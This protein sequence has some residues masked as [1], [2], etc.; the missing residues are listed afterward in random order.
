MV[1]L[2]KYGALSGGEKYNINVLNIDGLS[3]DTKP[4]TTFIEYGNDGREIGRMGIPNGS[5]YTEIDTGDTYMYDRDNA[6]WH[7]VS[8]GGGGGSTQGGIV[9][10]GETTTTLADEA[11]TN[12]ITVD[13]QSYT[14][15]PND[16]VI[17]GS[18]EFLFDGTKWHEFG[19][20][21]GLASKDIGAMTNYVKAQTGAAIVAT[22]TLN[23]A[24][25]KVE[26][27]VDEN[28]NAIDGQQ[29]TTASGG[30]G[31]AFINGIRLY[32][33]STAPTGDIPDGSVGVGW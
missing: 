31:Y 21:S 32:V 6:T 27:R 33:S 28:Q 10:V 12:P 18:K 30:N 16:A 2:I 3:T 8:I 23:E 11:T 13:G 7:K 4:I 24:I 1:T 17:Y 15:Q 20:L 22:D 14:A 26:K 25:G 29:N 19:D 5:L 9:L